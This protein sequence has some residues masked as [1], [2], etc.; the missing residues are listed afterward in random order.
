MTEPRDSRQIK[1]IT[2]VYELKKEKLKSQIQQLDGSIAKKKQS[3]QRFEEYAEAY[4]GKCDSMSF[5]TVQ[6]IKNN[7]AFYQNLARVI[8]SEKNDLQRLETIKKDLVGT[9]TAF[10][11]KTD[12]LNDL[13]QQLERDKQAAL[14]KI[15]DGINNDL[16]YT[17]NSRGKD[18]GVHGSSPRRFGNR[19]IT[20]FIEPIQG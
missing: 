20:M 7:Q 3:I 2:R 5:S 10:S 8:D 14:D 12:G 13:C 15:D 6:I 11:R 18:H 19:E 9:Y 16:A 1:T 4:A 17:T